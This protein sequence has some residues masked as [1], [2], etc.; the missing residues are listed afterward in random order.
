[1]ILFGFLIIFSFCT[2]AKGI[3]MT[4]YESLKFQIWGFVL[5]LVGII[6]AIAAFYM[7]LI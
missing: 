3:K 7:P 5:I 4:L 2:I 6:L 1:M